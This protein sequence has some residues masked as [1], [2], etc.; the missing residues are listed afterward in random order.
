MRLAVRSRLGDW[1]NYQ[2]FDL[3]FQT[4]PISVEREIVSF[5]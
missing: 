4:D 3:D 1:N 5:L 2:H